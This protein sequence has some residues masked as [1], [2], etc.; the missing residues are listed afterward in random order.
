[1]HEWQA[2]GEQLPADVA[3]GP[4][5]RPA[6]DAPTAFAGMLQPMAGHRGYGLALMWEVLTG[7]LAGGPRFA[8]ENAMPAD[9]GNPTG[10]SMFLLA[11]DPRAAMPYETFTARVD[12]MIDR[13]HASPAQDGFDRVRVPGERS[14]SIA[15]ERATAGVPIPNEVVATL[16]D[17]G[18][19]HGISL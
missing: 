11:L 15:R 18:A 6:L 12:E 1:M 10:G 4:D 14:A 9:F 19:E 3:L 2:R 5:G 13:M 17:L 8:G 16:N 7:V